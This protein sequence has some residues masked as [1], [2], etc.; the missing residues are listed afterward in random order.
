MTRIGREAVDWL[1]NYL[2][3][4]QRE[5]AVKILGKLLDNNVIHHVMDKLPFLDS[6]NL[7][8]FRV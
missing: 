5:H 6:E 4:A 3:L 7:Y 8:R 1:V 2:E